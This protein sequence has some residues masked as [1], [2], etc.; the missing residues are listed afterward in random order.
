MNQNLGLQDG[1]MIPSVGVVKYEFTVVMVNVK[2]R[3][4][5]HIH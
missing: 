4:P 2:E 3:R 1:N 5:S